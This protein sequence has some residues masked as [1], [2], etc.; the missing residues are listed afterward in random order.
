MYL[1]RMTDAC[2]NAGLPANWYIRIG[3]MDGDQEVFCL[4]NDMDMLMVQ[5]NEVLGELLEDSL[6]S[7]ELSRIRKKV[8]KD[9]WG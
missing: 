3:K 2:S 7:G 6:F 1:P 8:L 4:L 5:Q 9:T